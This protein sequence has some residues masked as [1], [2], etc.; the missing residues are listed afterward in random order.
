MLQEA[1]AGLFES[2]K[3]IQERFYTPQSRPQ[4]KSEQ[5]S[6]QSYDALLASLKAQTK[7]DVEEPF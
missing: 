3:T 2:A 4:V 5:H 6:L 7:H 1:R